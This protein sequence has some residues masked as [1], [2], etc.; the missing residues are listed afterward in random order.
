MVQ[1]KKLKINFNMTTFDATA[2]E[3]CLRQHNQLLILKTK[4]YEKFTH[5][6]LPPT[7]NLL[8]SIS[9]GDLRHRCTK[10]R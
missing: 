4:H 10:R 2:D 1:Q 9:F 5:L 8:W 7:R 3:L 6:S